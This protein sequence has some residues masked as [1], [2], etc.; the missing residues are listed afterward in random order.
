MMVIS[1]GWY[2]ISWRVFKYRSIIYNSHRVSWA[3]CTQLYDKF[4]SQY[5]IDEYNS[6]RQFLK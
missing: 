6:K 1:H 4:T 5:T 2:G 3:I